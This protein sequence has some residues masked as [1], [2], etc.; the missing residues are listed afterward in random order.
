MC[1]KPFST[2]NKNYVNCSRKCVQLFNIKNKSFVVKCQPGCTCKRHAK[3]EL[4]EEHRKKLS[5]ANRNPPKQIICKWCH[6]QYEI[7]GRDKRFNYCS[8]ICSLKSWHS[9]KNHNLHNK[10]IEE[11][12][13]QNQSTN[14]CGINV[15]AFL[16]D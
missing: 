3:R 6:K 15:P 9:K 7:V 4:S 10:K 11:N 14:D 2:R 1:H 5:D 8:R 13:E 16:R 12:H